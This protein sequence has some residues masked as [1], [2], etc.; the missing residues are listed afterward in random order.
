[1][2]L[3]FASALFCGILLL[4]ASAAEVPFSAVVET[5]EFK[6]VSPDVQK[7]VAGQIGVRPGDMLTA[8]ARQRI[9][10]GLRKV[11]KGLTFTYRSGSKP[12]T[13]KVIISGDC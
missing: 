13:A 1:M 11:R 6:A 4:P 9:G 12:A 5:I 8:E 3:T 10:S 2:K 7:L